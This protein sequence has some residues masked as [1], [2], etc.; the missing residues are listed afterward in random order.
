MAHPNDASLRLT[1]GRGIAE[2]LRYRVERLI[3]K[4]NERDAG[5]IDALRDVQRMMND[6]ELPDFD[7]ASPATQEPPRA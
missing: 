6:G 5:Y 4:P 3:Q 2:A 7:Y 1:L